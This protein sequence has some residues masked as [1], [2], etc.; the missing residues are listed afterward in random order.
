MKKSLARDSSPHLGISLPVPEVPTTAP[1]VRPP[2]AAAHHPAKAAAQDLAG[3]D[4]SLTFNFPSPTSEGPAAPAPLV[5]P[6]RPCASPAPA[7]RRHYGPRRPPT[8]ARVA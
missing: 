3:C 7:T 8:R 1:P 5:R 4:T 6:P 2:A